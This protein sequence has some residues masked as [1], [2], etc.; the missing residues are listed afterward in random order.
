MSCHGYDRPKPKKCRKQ[1]N[2]HLSSQTTIANRLESTFPPHLC[3][4]IKFVPDSRQPFENGRILNLAVG[5]TLQIATHHAR[6][7]GE[8][9][10][11]VTFLPLHVLACSSTRKSCVFSPL[12][13]QVVLRMA[14]AT[15][16]VCA[17]CLHERRDSRVLKCLHS[18]CKECIDQL[19]VP[20]ESGKLEVECPLC[21]TRAQ[22]PDGGA[23]SLPRDISTAQQSGTLPN[24]Q[25]CEEKG[26]CGQ[27][28]MWCTKCECALCFSHIADHMASL[29][30]PSSHAI[31]GEIPKAGSKLADDGPA[32]CQDHNSPLKYFCSTCDVPVCGDCT[33]V[34]RHNGHRP[35]VPM[36][37]VV[38]K[39][40]KK[41]LAKTD[42]LERVVLPRVEQAIAKVDE[43]STDLTGRAK[44]VRAEV[45]AAG[46]RA[47]DTI[48]ASV[49]QKL[50]DID[51][52]EQVRHKALDRQSDELKR[53]AQAVKNA[54]VFGEKLRHDVGGGERLGG[55]LATLDDRA[56]AL[57]SVK[58]TETPVSHSRLSFAGV[59]D[60]EL[61]RK[62]NELVGDVLQCNVSASHSGV[63]GSNTKTTK[64]GERASFTVIAVDCNGEAVTQGGNVVSARWVNA[65][66]PI[67]QLPDMEVQDM[68]NG[69]YGI[70]CP[71]P[72][73]GDYTVE[74]SINGTPLSDVLSITCHGG[75]FHFDETECQAV[76]TV[77]PDK[78]T[79]THTGEASA[80]SSVLGSCGVN[81]GQHCWKVNLDVPDGWSAFAFVGVAQKHA[82]KPVDNYKQT[83]SWCS[84]GNCFKMG[85][86]ENSVRQFIG[87][88]SVQL[89]LDCDTHTLKF[90]NL[91]TGQT[92]TIDNL[93]ADE[94]FPYFATWYENSKLTLD[95]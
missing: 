73:D 12:A 66:V 22:L 63:E 65:P 24:C 49:E 17:V 83:Y 82:L 46:E 28:A 91:R 74:L 89:D 60:D 64:K 84:N 36:K 71:T 6:G 16:D 33:A 87:D 52:I 37:D 53:H 61:I 70:T 45:E 76:H 78:M 3:K 21:R 10:K 85:K 62:A 86:Y 30:G 34:G 20:L 94:L 29:S 4:K 8:E 81:N 1:L 7:G 77:S 67:D 19:A 50:Q 54:I 95:W 88:A 38:A 15:P 92:A 11:R 80:W 47:V 44:E 93:P 18:F 75:W 25:A 23:A 58:L 59:S 27:A 55:L 9:I 43:V 56:T 42:R 26:E 69:R 68:E 35:I 48:R 90:T 39:L 2:G 79:V 40:A 32:L 31:V 57:E 5:L 41:V 14:S 72:L 13:R 51:D